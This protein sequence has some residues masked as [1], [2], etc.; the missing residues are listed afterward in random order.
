[1]ELGSIL[2]VDDNVV[3]AATRQAI[4]RSAGHK[5]IA[6][7]DP[8]RALE[9][10]EQHSLPDSI[11]LVVTDH[12]MPTMTGSTFV[13]KLRQLLP[14]VPVIVI[15]GLEEAE[16]EYKGLDIHFRMKPLNPELLLDTVDQFRT[17]VLNSTT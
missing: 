6:V 7:L 1:M 13:R 14:T 5:V 15:S 16:D 9:S 12:L 10:L 8:R 11:W 17:A 3:Q 2:L 4:L